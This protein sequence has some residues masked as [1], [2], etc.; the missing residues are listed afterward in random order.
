MQINITLG[1]PNLVRV[2]E[3]VIIPEEVSISFTSYLYALGTLVGT[4]RCGEKIKK[5]KTTGEPVDL[6]ELFSRAGKVDIELSML[7]GGEAVKTWRLEPILVK[8]I[9]HELRAIPEIDALN[10]RIDTLEAALSE[11]ASLI[12]SNETI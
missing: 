11:L 3:C 8:E 10:E 7:A 4:A 6:S 2:N 1:T 5:F 12:K 9:E